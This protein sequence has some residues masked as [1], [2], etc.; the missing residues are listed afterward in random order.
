MVEKKILVYLP[1]EDQQIVELVLRPLKNHQFF[2]YGGTAKPR[3]ETNLHY[4]PFSRT[5]FLN[6]LMD[7]EGVICNAGF[8]LPSEVLHLGKKLL[9]RPL[10][11]QMEQISNA[12]ALS[13]LNLGTVMSRLEGHT[14]ASWLNSRKTC[15]ISYPNV[16]E[17]LAG[18]IGNGGWQNSDLETFAAS[19]WN[20]TE[21][22]LYSE[23]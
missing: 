20:Q 10:S 11:G 8:Q 15:Q 6:D 13:R 18:W 1:F 17:L 23:T 22:S 19:I 2:I 5:G 14:I 21:M 4:R 12:L 9:V 7:C 16:A 3:D